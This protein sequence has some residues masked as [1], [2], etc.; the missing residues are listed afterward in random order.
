MAL[1]C[2]FGLGELGTE[3]NSRQFSD[4]IR[5]ISG[6]GVCVMGGKLEMIISGFAVKLSTGYAL[7]AGR[8]IENDEPFLLMIPPSGSHED[9]VDAVVANVDEETR[10]AALEI[11]SGV[12]P[13]APPDGTLYLIHIKRGAAFLTAENV[14]D[15]RQYV[16]PLSELSAGALRVYEFLASGIDREVARLMALSEKLVDKADA[17]IAE[18]DA[19]I[20]RLGGGPGLGELMTARRKPVPAAGWILCD[21]GDVPRAYPEL[22]ALLGGKLPDI[23]GERYPTYIYGGTPMS[24]DELH[25]PY[26]PSGSDGYVTADGEIYCCLRR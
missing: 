14:T 12:D 20:Q 10:K 2:G 21:G 23:P 8:W 9:R 13:A 4:A 7:T 18:L 5:Q 22:S 25:Y 15:I 16:I 11:L 24:E 6:D 19:E 17:A 3:Y 1:T 26:V